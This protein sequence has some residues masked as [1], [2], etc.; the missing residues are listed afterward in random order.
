LRG[1]N[2]DG[3]VLERAN[4]RWADLDGATLPDGTTRR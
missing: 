4:L 3:A 1:A 2:L